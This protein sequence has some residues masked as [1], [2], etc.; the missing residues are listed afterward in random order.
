MASAP[1]F[2]PDLELAT[3]GGQTMGT[4]WSV[5]LC[6]PPQTDLHRLHAGIQAQLD[7]VVAQMSTWR[8]DSDISR[9]NKAV[10]GSW[11]PLPAQFE[12]VL[13]CAL[14]IARATDGAFDP[15]LGPLVAA[16]GFG[17]HG[18]GFAVPSE[19]SIARVRQH[20]GW[21]RL[22][23]R[24]HAPRELLQPGELQ[25]DLSAIAKGFGVDQVARWL[26]MRGV[27]GG[28]VEVGGE[29]FGWGLRPDGARWRVLV[30]TA[31]ELDAE[32]EPCVLALDGTAVATSGDHWHHFETA[33]TRYAHTLDARSGQ[34]VAQAAA[35]VTV[36]ADSAMQADAW[37]T[38]LTVMGP[39]AGLAFAQARGMAARFVTRAQ[40]G[41]L[42]HATRAFDARTTACQ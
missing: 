11:H 4:T 15:T 25:L 24:G 17:A 2:V 9:Y 19:A 36:L 18:R 35:A 41:P 14:E 20:V 6:L 40:A 13:S 16:W 37:A 1:S 42:I 27:L 3:L 29:L 8:E 34:P 39:T 31:S 7:E 23:W 30:E 38:A 33:G 28:L 22:Q 12:I 32:A 26:R 21:Q 5:K 10:A